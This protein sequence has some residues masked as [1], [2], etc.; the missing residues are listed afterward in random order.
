M[1]QVQHLSQHFGSTRA[2]DD[3]SFEVEPG[4]ITAFLGPNGAGKSTTMRTMV[5]L[6][7]PTGGR[8]LIDGRRYREIP[9]PLRVVGTLLDGNHFHPARSAYSHLRYLAESNRLPR[10]RVGEVAALTGI[11][12]VVGRRVGRFSLGMKQRLGIAAALLGDPEVLILDEPNNGLD[13]EGI[14]WLRGLLASM[15]AEGRTVLVSSHLITE[16]AL[17]ASHLIVIGRG[18]LLAD[19]RIEDLVM[20][21]TGPRSRRRYL[22]LTHG[23]ATSQRSLRRR[24]PVTRAP[25]R[26]ELIKLGSLPSTYVLIAAAVTIG[27]GVGP[28]GHSLDRTPLAAARSAGPR[29]L[30]PRRR[31][32]LGLPVHRTRLRRLRCAGHQSEYATGTM[33]ATLVASPRRCRCTLAK[34]VALTIVVLPI[35]VASTFLAFILGQRAVAPRHLDVACPTP[36]PAGRGRAGLCTWLSSPSSGSAWAPSSDTRRERSPSC[37]RWCSLRGRSRG[38]SRHQRTSPTAGSSSTPPTRS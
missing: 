21:R 3:L 23:T 2:V 27:L 31:L 10:A 14:S 25:L 19:A 15:A 12:A 13:P 33:H 22:A 18:R 6:N 36:C 5:G 37:S 4:V 8:V 34:V 7:T 9:Q 32:V 26:S 20:P 17:S 11:D 28:A 16:V 35:C 24:C 29:I 38:R 30:R 1:I